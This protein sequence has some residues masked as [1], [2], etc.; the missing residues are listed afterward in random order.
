M[1]ETRPARRD[2]QGQ[3]THTAKDLAVAATVHHVAVTYVLPLGLTA[4]AAI[5]SYSEGLSLTTAIVACSLTFGGVTTGLVRF[6]EWRDRRRVSDKLNLTN[7][8][9]GK[10]MRG[11]ELFV[12]VAFANT[13]S[14]P[15]DFEVSQIRSRIGT[16][17]PVNP[18]DGA[19][20]TI[21]AHGNGWVHDGGIQIAAP[22]KPGTLEGFVEA[23]IMYGRAGGKRKHELLVKKHLIVA[24]D[25]NG[26]Y[27]GSTWHDAA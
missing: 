10:E 27:Q 25:G 8:Y 3:V 16:T 14:V 24:F 17:V 20:G 4:L 5:G 13:A 15:V 19:Y 22:P 7:A 1:P 23:R 21:P 6:D 2:L 26:L 18:N 9:V 12:G 11:P